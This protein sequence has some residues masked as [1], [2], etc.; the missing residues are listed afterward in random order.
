MDGVLILTLS[1][2]AVLRYMNSNDP[3]TVE[4]LIAKTECLELQEVN[5]PRE[6]KLNDTFY[7]DTD[8]FSRIIHM[9]GFPKGS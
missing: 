4:K 3:E 9:L 7:E 8:A 1:L 2:I 5:E 6:T